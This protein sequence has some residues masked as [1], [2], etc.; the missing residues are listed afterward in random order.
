MPVRRRGRTPTVSPSGRVLAE[1]FR[2]SPQRW[3]RTPPVLGSRRCGRTALCPQGVQRLSD[4]QAAPPPE[5]KVT[6]AAQTG[7]RGGADKKIR[8]GEYRGGFPEP[9]QRGSGV[10]AGEKRP[11]REDD[12]DASILRLAHTER[13]GNPRIVHAATRDDHVVARHAHPFEGDRY[14]VCAPL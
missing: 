11:L 4:R 6:I 9:L 12:L 13:R 3:N 5:S 8:R 14:G 10:S 2:S 7:R 1:R